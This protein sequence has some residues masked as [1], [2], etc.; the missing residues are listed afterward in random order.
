[1]MITYLIK[2]VLLMKIKG[3]VEVWEGG[4]VII[5]FKNKKKNR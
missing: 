2:K 5:K 4:A 3:D 1:M